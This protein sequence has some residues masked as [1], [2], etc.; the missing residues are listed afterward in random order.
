MLNNVTKG[1]G[2]QET[3]SERP[4]DGHGK[5]QHIVEQLGQK[6]FTELCEIARKNGDIEKTLEHSRYVETYEDAVWEICI[7]WYANNKL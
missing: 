1:Y 5:R 3:F 6:D 7:E 2:D 4:W